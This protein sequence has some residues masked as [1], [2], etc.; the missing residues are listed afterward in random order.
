[1][2]AQLCRKLSTEQRLQ[3]FAGLSVWMRLGDGCLD[4]IVGSSD[5]MRSLE[6][7]LVQ[8]RSAMPSGDD[9]YA[10]IRRKLQAFMSTARDVAGD[11][12]LQSSPS[13]MAVGAR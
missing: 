1:V 5:L 6:C 7:L 9:D 4:G 2:S 12:R 13:T 11:S 3:F 10:A 8:I